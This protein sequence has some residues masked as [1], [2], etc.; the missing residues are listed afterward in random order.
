[1]MIQHCKCKVYYV[2]TRERTLRAQP[3]ALFTS[4]VLVSDRSVP[5]D[6]SYIGLEEIV[7]V[8]A[9]AMAVEMSAHG[10]Y[11][12]VQ[13][14]LSFDQRSKQVESNGSNG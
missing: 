4:E 2:Y 14:R 10:Q 5:E 13:V 12:F 3:Y 1:M 9:E 6:S 7:I 11:A 8:E